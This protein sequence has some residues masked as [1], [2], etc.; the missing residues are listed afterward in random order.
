M[1]D[2]TVRGARIYFRNFSGKK[3]MYN[4]EGDRNFSVRFNDEQ[5]EDLKAKGWNV[6]TKPAR[7]EGDED[8]HHLKVK[9]KFDFKPPAVWLVTRQGTRKTKLPENLVGMLDYADLETVDLTFSPSRWK[10][11]DGRTG[12]TAY[13][14]TIFATLREDPLEILYQDVQ[15]TSAI[16][17]DL[18]GLISIGG[19]SAR[20]ALPAGSAEEEA[21]YTYDFD[22]KQE[23]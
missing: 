23:S 11:Q 1:D 5:A 21:D 3:G 9:V 10:M 2:V 6:K 22:G 17:A 12:V 14:R 8:F 18:D 19:G 16:E 20:P 7:E 13:L 4:A 15:D